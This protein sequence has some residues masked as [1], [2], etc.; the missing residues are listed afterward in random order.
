MTPQQLY[1]YTI[2]C[3]EHG[4]NVPIED[5]YEFIIIFSPIKNWDGYYRHSGYWETIEDAKKSL[6]YL[7]GC[8][9]EEFL[10][11]AEEKNWQLHS[12]P[13]PFEFKEYKVGDK[14]KISERFRELLD[15]LDIDGWNDE[16]KELIGKEY[17]VT[18]V[19]GEGC[20]IEGVWVGFNYLIPAQD[21][22]TTLIKQEIAEKFNIDVNNLEIE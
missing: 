5:K 11:D 13:F 22:K 3:L 18:V 19:D 21:S 1:D 6:C 10:E 20:Y 14:V 15:L 2:K 8:S 4:L 7:L 12:D 9:K 17:E 16:L